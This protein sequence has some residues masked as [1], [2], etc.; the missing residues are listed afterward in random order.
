[1][2]EKIAIIGIGCRFPGAENAESFWQLLSNKIDAVSELSS[3]PFDLHMLDYHPIVPTTGKTK[4]LWG[5][6]L[7]KV[8]YFDPGFF[9]ISPIE[10]ER[11]DP[12]QRLFLEVAWESLENAGIVPSSELSGSKTGVFV[13][14]YNYDYGLVLSRE[15]SQI[16]AY[17]A[18]G[19]NLS[20]IANRLSYFLNL[21]GPSLV[22]DTACSSSLVALHYAC[23]SLLTGESNLCLAAGVNLILSPERT[24]SLSHAQMMAADGRCKTFDAAADGY[25]QGEGCGVVVLKRLADAI[26]DGDNIQAIIRGSAVNQNGLSNGLVAPNGPSQQA[27]IRQALANAG[28][29]PAQISYVETQGTGTAMGDSIEVNALKAVLMEGREANQPCW[30]GS[31]KTN[32]GHLEGAAGI[33]GLIKVVLSLQQSQIPPHLHLK[34]LNPYIKIQNTPIQIPTELQ[35]WPATE[36]PR[37]AGVSAFSFGGTNAHV[38][39]EEAPV[40]VKSQK[41]TVN[42]KELPER[43]YH[44]LTLSAKTETAL[45]ALINRYQH[46]LETHPNQAIADIC[47]TA[48]RG[49]SHFD[50]RLA[51]VVD[52]KEQLIKQL[53]AFVDGKETSELITAQVM[54]KR[55]PKIAFLF[56]AQGFEYVNI[57]R[58]LYDTQPIFRNA[59]KQ[60]DRILGLYLEHSL[61]EILYPSQAGNDVSSVLEQTAY[62]Q[63]ALFAL[64]YALYQLWKSWN[65]EPDVLMGHNVGEYVAACIAGVF[66]LEDALKLIAQRSAYPSMQPKVAEQIS[67]SQPQIKIIVNGK[68][69]NSEIA[70]PEYW[71]QH[72]QSTLQFA[73]S[74]AI[75]Q[76]LG[77]TAFVEIG[78]KPTLLAMAKQSLPEDAGLW[79]PSLN[80]DIPDWQQLL[81]SLAQ[82][83]VRG[84]AVD[85]LGFDQEYPRNKVVLPTYPFERQRYWIDKSKSLG[86]KTS[87]FKS[88]GENIHPLLG[89][90]LYLAG[91]E[92]IRFQSEISPKQ[93][94]YLQDYRIYRQVILPEGAYLEMALAA[95]KT[96]TSANVTL[97]HVVFTQALHLSEDAEVTVQVVLTPQKTGSYTF[98]IF[99][100][101]LESDTPEPIYT[102]HA[103]GKVELVDKEYQP[104]Q[105]N[106][107]TCLNLC[108]QVVEVN[109][110]YQ[111]CRQKNIDYGE[112]LQAIA[113]LWRGERTALALVELPTKLILAADYQL[114][115]VLLNASLSA[116]AAALPSNVSWDT[117]LP[118][119]LERLR[120]YQRC[121]SRL[122]SQ[123][124]S[125]TVEGTNQQILRSNICLFDDSGAV[126]AEIKGLTLKRTSNFTQHLEFVYQLQQTPIESRESLVKA[127][128][129]EQIAQGLGLQVT[130]V[131][132]SASLKNLGFDSLIAVELRNRILKKLGVDI[133]II[134]FLENPTIENLT[135]EVLTQLPTAK[136]LQTVV[137]SSEKLPLELVPLQIQ[138]SK[139]PLFFA[140]PL[141]GVV[142]PYYE[143][144][145][146]LDSERPFYGLQSIGLLNQDEPLTS[147][148]EMAATY[149][150]A[151]KKVQP[152]GPYYLG[153]WSLGAYIAWEM[154]VQ[155]TQAKEEVAFLGIVDIPPPAVGEIANF[156]FL[157]KFLLTQ[158]LLYV[159]PYVYDFLGIENA[160]A[161]QKQK[162]PQNLSLLHIRILQFFQKFGYRIPAA[163]RLLRVLQAN[164]KAMSN[165]MPPLYG[166]KM[167]LLRTDKPMGNSFD[168]PTLGWNKFAKAEVEI[169]LFPGNHFTLLRQPHIH[170]LAQQLKSLLDKAEIESSPVINPYF[171]KMK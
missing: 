83:Y 85:W 92:Q 38:V 78:P 146:H 99:S 142:F 55:R 15:Y 129:Q 26:R 82:L 35:Q 138:G 43:S 20:I 145:T 108:P 118:V 34:K 148:E 68:V 59:L 89:Q 144:A 70:T 161:T 130:Q 167:T 94:I 151:L 100:L 23:Q 136:S 128:L 110:Y 96:V 53:N 91:S 71:V 28:V 163:A 56:T 17:N 57:G 21:R 73:E 109:Q 45:Q 112:N 123:V 135:T 98:E 122:W 117:Y 22:I 27:V 5:G 7:P 66:S 115:P 139:P 12:Q 143:L 3:R 4:R 111:L 25:V 154:A 47:F 155:L 75:L 2:M 120:V 125:L 42:D 124:Q 1:M 24:I 168:E 102:S 6:F 153:G 165:Y 80:A 69:A 140:H 137:A 41:S 54:S 49:R 48:N 107:N 58:Q 79:V 164:T 133:S 106:L 162:Q 127:L 72:G 9:Q 36:Q 156:N 10:A 29:E 51:I 147:V 50:H 150:E 46:H 86:Q 105:V 141:A 13:G 32:I 134:K 97:S 37:L 40:K 113:Q 101:Q 152:S 67:Y 160:I 18:I 132:V 8:E 14:V 88:A 52:S 158:V 64:E 61:L 95:V 84:V 19:N 31:V 63:P 39:L 166:G 90:R 30:I 87:F 104:K 60:C 169:H 119:G 62:I 170:T 33:A 116:I 114:H 171:Q 65:I 76:Q 93:P 121:V 131:D 77:I 44:L 157:S 159:W 149:I 81:K 11:I 126:I 74:M 103:T 16:N